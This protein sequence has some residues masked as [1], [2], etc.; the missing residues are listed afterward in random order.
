MNKEKMQSIIQQNLLLP[1]RSFVKFTFLGSMTSQ[2]HFQKSDSLPHEM[3]SH[4]EEA[5]GDF[6]KCP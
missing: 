3:P 4:H 2:G 1:L 6:W 5:N